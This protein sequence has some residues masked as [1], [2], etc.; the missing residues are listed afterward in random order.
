MRNLDLGALVI[1]K[2][3]AEEGTVNASRRPVAPRTV[4][5][6]GEYAVLEHSGPAQYGLD[7]IPLRWSAILS[8]LAPRA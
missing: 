6:N 2:A 4:E 8:L 7:F 5:C 1:F 3:V